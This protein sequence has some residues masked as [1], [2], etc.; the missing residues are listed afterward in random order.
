MWR[1]LGGN[2]VRGWS[3]KCAK[4]LFRHICQWPLVFSYPQLITNVTSAST[5]TSTSTSTLTF[6]STSARNT[7]PFHCKCSYLHFSFLT[8]ALRS[9]F[10]YHYLSF[11]FILMY[12][13]LASK[14]PR[15]RWSGSE[16][17]VG[18]GF[19]GGFS[20]ADSFSSANTNMRCSS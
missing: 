13:R 18:L 5:S 16:N 4:Y 11:E 15:F 1:F 6:T 19:S 9:V 8:F 14:Y 10:C 20:L 3:G 12:F 2:M 17:G 7:H